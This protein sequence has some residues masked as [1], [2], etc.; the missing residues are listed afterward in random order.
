FSTGELGA[1]RSVDDPATRPIAVDPDLKPTFTDE[2]TAGV[3]HE[4]MP[5]VSFSGAF[6]ARNDKDFDW[7]INRDVSVADYTGINGA[8]AGPDGR[9]GSTDDGGALVFYELSAAKRA[10]SPNYIT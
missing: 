1:I 3:V 7:R 8:D 9:I 2:F 4:L 5:N 10:L 6:I